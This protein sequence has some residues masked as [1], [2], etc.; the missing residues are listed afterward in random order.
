MFD[1]T[2]SFGLLVNEV[3]KGTWESS[4]EAFQLLCNINEISGDEVASAAQIIS[5]ADNSSL[6][7]SWRKDL[8]ESLRSMFS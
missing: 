5:Q 4:H 3:L 8:V 7:P 6:E 2:S 1:Y